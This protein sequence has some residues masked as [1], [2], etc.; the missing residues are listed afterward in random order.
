MLGVR[1]ESAARLVKAAQDELDERVFVE[2]VTGPHQ[3]QR[4][5]APVHAIHAQVRRHVVRETLVAL[6]LQLLHKGH[7]L[8]DQQRH[9]GGTWTTVRVFMP[10]R[11][12]SLHAF[13]GAPRAPKRARVE[14]EDAQ[15]KEAPVPEERE[16]EARE[17]EEPMPD[18]PPSRAST[19][20]LDTLRFD[21]HAS[22]ASLTPPPNRP[23][24]PTHAAF[25][26]VVAPR[27][28]ATQGAIKYTPL[29]Q[30]ILQLKKENPGVL[31]LVEVGYKMKFYQE[32]ARIASQLLNIV[33]LCTDPG[34]LSG[35][36]PRG[37]HDSRAPPLGARQAPRCA[38]LQGRCVP[39]DGD[40]RAQG[41]DRECEQALYAP[42]HGAVHGQHLDRRSWR[43][44]VARP[45]RRR[46]GAAHRLGAAAR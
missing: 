34:V 4:A 23:P 41:R 27:H 28:K 2:R 18:A 33:R 11:Q 20:L 21:A 15:E 3:R 12:A 10:P 44:A 43:R 45:A 1:P 26:S 16:V 6:L 5:H 17:A 25:T 31:L 40:A 22:E 42:A 46:A 35:K 30:Q 38:R 37:G 9:R 14:E 32:D 29:E 39:P 24:R 13:F 8:L 36:E 19:N 7:M